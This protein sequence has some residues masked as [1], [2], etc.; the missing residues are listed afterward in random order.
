MLSIKSFENIYFYRPFADFRKGID[1]LCLI[2]QDEMMLNPFE[3]YLFI[4]C[5]AKRDK[6]KVLYWDKTGFALWYKRLE[7]DK[8]KWPSHLESE[9]IEINVKVLRKFLIGLNPWEKP[10]EKLNFS[11]A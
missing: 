1:G 8:Y 3:N 2:V 11:V 4:F 5:N 10:H 7:R 6:I 9:T